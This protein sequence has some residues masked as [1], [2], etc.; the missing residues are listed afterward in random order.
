MWTIVNL[1]SR[2]VDI[3]FQSFLGNVS[4]VGTLKS[5][6]SLCTDKIAVGGYL[7]SYKKNGELLSPPFPVTERSSRILIGGSQRNEIEHNGADIRAFPAFA[8]IP[9]IRL[10]NKLSIPVEVYYQ[11]TRQLCDPNNSYAF[12]NNC[13]LTNKLIAKLNPWN[14]NNRASYLGGSY[15]DLDVQNYY[16]NG[17]FVGDIFT[18]V[19]GETGE[20]LFQATIADEYV[21][22]IEVGTT[23]GG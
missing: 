4:K 17:F 3:Y 13:G 21:R 22:T 6:D 9:S 10:E 18:F 7:A 19:D 11:C 5:H 20:L 2:E 15:A 8:D 23:I 16:P 12:R 1:F 14:P